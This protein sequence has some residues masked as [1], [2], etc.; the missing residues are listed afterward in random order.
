MY[1]HM[2][3]LEIEIGRLSNLK[4]VH[5][6]NLIAQNDEVGA[7]AV[8]DGEDRQINL[9]ALDLHYE[10]L[11]AKVVTCYREQKDRERI[12]MDPQTRAVLDSL[13][14]AESVFEKPDFWGNVPRTILQDQPNI[15]P[16]SYSD[17]LVVPL[18]R[19]YIRELH[20]FYKVPIEWK[21]LSASWHGRGV[22]DAVIGEQELHF[23]YRIRRRNGGEY[24]V[25]I[26][27]YLGKT[28]QLKIQ[29]RFERLGVKVY[30]SCL[31]FGL[32]GYS[33]YTIDTNGA[34]ITEKTGITVVGKTVYE[35]ME[36]LAE[37]DAD[38]KE[39]LRRKISEDRLMHLLVRDWDRARVARLPW[40][41][42]IVYAISNKDDASMKKQDIEVAYLLMEDKHDIIRKHSFSHIVGRENKVEID[43]RYARGDIYVQKGTKE[44]VQIAFEDTGYC[45]FDEYKESYSGRFLV[46]EL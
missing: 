45:S 31:P 34:S 22:L 40:G 41:H 2:D 25:L 33:T 4:M 11:L 18:L 36:T 13:L 27:N 3:E 10:A 23:P 46:G 43:A 24:D 1:R 5:F 19:Y 21:L 44:R 42:Y 15:N 7:V 28:N 20:L 9:S 16:G 39:D 29:I 30:F 6:Y 26:G 17:Y 37:P 32:E 35:H 12:V 8:Y 38:Q 14:A